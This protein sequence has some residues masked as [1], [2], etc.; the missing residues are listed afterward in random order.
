MN[1]NILSK[2]ET[3]IISGNDKNELDP[4][5]FPS[6]PLP[7]FN[8]HQLPTP[9]LFSRSTPT[10]VSLSQSMPTPVLF[11]QSMP[12][13]QHSR[14]TPSLQSRFSPQN[15]SHVS[16]A[17]GNMSS[18]SKH[19]YFTPSDLTHGSGHKFFSDIVD[20]EL[21][22]TKSDN[23]ELSPSKSDEIELS[24]VDTSNREATLLQCP[25]N[26]ADV[27]DKQTDKVDHQICVNKTVDF[28][29]QSVTK[30]TQ[31]ELETISSFQNKATSSGQAANYLAII[32]NSEISSCFEKPKSQS[33][34]EPIAAITTSNKSEISV[35][36][37]DDICN[38][39]V[40]A[41]EDYLSPVQ[42][43][44]CLADITDCR[45][46]RCMFCPSYDPNN[47]AT[48]KHGDFG[49]LSFVV[50]NSNPVILVW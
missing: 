26:T 10:P 11:S 46:K 38:L 33:T 16:P 2:D 3:K 8:S 49:M 24:G 32:Q 27:R 20:A 1:K 44:D 29:P 22:P 18:S 14:P 37:D 19:S 50:I 35:N 30:K 31:N 42:F 45:D 13:L 25:V 28:L 15:S 4:T 34:V 7:I 40:E 36:E 17:P 47:I 48:S 41:E 21:S 6:Q 43:A 12:T 23:L 5:L 39:T 9:V